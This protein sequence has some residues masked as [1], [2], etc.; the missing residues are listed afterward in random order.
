M[1]SVTGRVC[2]C[3]GIDEPLQKFYTLNNNLCYYRD[4]IRFGKVQKVFHQISSI[5][6]IK[7]YSEYTCTSCTRD[8]KLIDI[9]LK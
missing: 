7:N 4:N 6:I 8:K 2:D 3:C 9:L 5:G 1:K